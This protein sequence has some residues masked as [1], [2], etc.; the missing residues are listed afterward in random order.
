MPGAV[1]GAE[2][3]RDATTHMAKAHFLRPLIDAPNQPFE[4]R[5]GSSNEV[6]A[7]HVEPALDSASRRRGLLGRDALPVDTAFVIAPTNAVHTFG[8]RFP[9]DLLF[10]RRDGRV[11]KRVVAVPRRRMS[12]ALRAFAV[13]EF[14]ANHPGVAMTRVGDQLQLTPAGRRR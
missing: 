8:M 5:N 1:S 10:V 11:V 13:I 9:I 4:L 7:P 12:A 2:A 6:I 14:C 3:L